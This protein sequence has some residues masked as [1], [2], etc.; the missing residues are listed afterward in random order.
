MPKRRR[1]RL[2]GGLARTISLVHT[3]ECS[4][5]GWGQ[6]KTDPNDVFDPIATNRS[7]RLQPGT[8]RRENHARGHG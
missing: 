6:T 4:F 3:V 2:E 1:S 7:E 8:T 5:V